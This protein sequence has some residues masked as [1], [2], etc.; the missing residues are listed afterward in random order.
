[1][2]EVLIPGC[3]FAAPIVACLRHTIQCATSG[4]PQ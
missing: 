2:R 4:T 3:L 1:M